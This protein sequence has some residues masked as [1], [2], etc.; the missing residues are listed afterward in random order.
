MADAIARAAELSPDDCRR[1][2][3]ARF[4]ARRMVDRYVSLYRELAVSARAEAR[5]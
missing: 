5:P 4:D 2:A 3:E 1:A